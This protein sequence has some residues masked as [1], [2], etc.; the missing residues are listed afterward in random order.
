MMPKKSKKP[1]S[2][3]KF[4][5]SVAGSAAGGLALVSCTGKL[6]EAAGAPA[7]A[8]L[9]PNFHPASCGWLDTFSEERVYCCNSYLDH[10]DRVR[11][12]PTYKFVL[13]ECNNIIAMMNFQPQRIPELK[14]RCKEGRVE[15]VNATFLEMTINLSGGEA[16]I[17]EGVEGLRWQE[18][19]MGF[20]P[21]FAWTI[22]ICGLH[23]QMG[24]ISSG[25]GLQALVYDRMNKTGSRIHWAESPDGSRILALCPVNYADFGP[26]FRTKVPLTADQLRKLE[27]ELREKKKTTPAGAP[28]LVLGGSGDYNLAPACKEYPK[29]FLKQWK[30]VNPETKL[31]VSTAGEYLDA[32]MPGIQSGK[33]QI[34]T[35]RGG[36][37]YTFDAFWIECPNSKTW[38]RRNEHGLQATES[39]ATIASLQSNFRYPTKEL[40]DAWIQML[41]NMDR[42]S[43]WGAAAG[44]VFTS[45]KS[46]C[47]QDR[48][49]SVQAINKRV[50]AAALEAISPRGNGLALFNPL[51]WERSDP[52]TLSLGPGQSLKGN[53]CQAM[54]GGQTLCKLRQPSFS[55]AA[56]EVEDQ[57]PA[58]SKRIPFPESIETGYYV[59][60]V[61]PK[62]GALESLKLKPSG[63]EM[64]SGPANVV[65][66]E[67][68]KSG[69]VDVGNF[70]VPRP[71]RLRL[72]SSSDSKSVVS[73]YSGPL[74]TTIVAEGEF[75]GGHPSR[76]VIHF[77]KEHPRIDFETDLQDI[78]NRT[79][80]VAEFPLKEE[81]REVRRGIPNGFS[82]AAWAKPN[83]N[84]HG[85]A[86]GIVPAVRWIDFALSGGGGVALLDR[87]LTGRELNGST[88]IIYLYN[89]TDKYIGYPNPWLNGQG[90]HHFEY[91][92]VAHESAWRDARIPQMGW[93]YNSPPLW[94]AGRKAA[95]AKSWV[96]TSNNLIVQAVR[97][98]E[99]EIEMRLLEYLGLPG[100]GVVTLNLP[101]HG[102][103]LTNL[104]GKNGSPLKGESPYRFPVR[105]HQIVT[106]RFRT[107]TAVEKI[108]PILKWDP[109]VPKSKL[110]ALHQYGSYMGHPPPGD[111]S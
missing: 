92:L 36:T 75:Y 85:W 84:L 15:L 109:L 69:H 1:I 21:R 88:P 104:R 33:I 101:H 65:V 47:V 74:A 99:S 48:M 62:T 40:Y 22:D 23:D 95:A 45:Q 63:R 76:R 16:L 87:G 68:P 29:E 64:L 103:S 41:L 77:Y 12:D 38:Y 2:R 110:A 32:I 60:R 20:S 8:Y 67:R 46:W 86:K 52:I 27:Q 80:V 73:A 56:A 14:Q 111:K 71:E 81:I 19:V 82:H 79:V 3:R 28:I 94:I 18:E 17:K 11:D 102:A 24:Q 108:K 105:S 42:N 35:M 72:A 97:R 26:V 44:M 13:S 51:N 53:E 107:E 50:Q 93:E 55:V 4:L 90:K 78:P 10:L 25:L 98:E 7:E 43:L 31:Q 54:H 58:E 70:M 100:T 89:A 96:E 9:V 91:A 57:K 39:L 34:P 49:E 30:Q 83:P 61:N 6:H 66:A 5:A 37:G 106:L 59:A